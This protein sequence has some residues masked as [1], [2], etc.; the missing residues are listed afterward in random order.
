MLYEKQE[1]KIVKN[2]KCK[3]NS[4]NLI[5]TRADNSGVIKLKCLTCQ[6]VYTGQ[7]GRN[8][9]TSYKGHIGEIRHNTQNTGYAQHKLS[10]GHEYGNLEN[11][12]D[13]VEQQHKGPCLDTTENF[14][15]IH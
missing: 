8:C 3:L 12:M 1:Y 13:I 2:I 5:V 6:G 4:N 14:Q 11:A 9:K 10:T 7:T 15:Y